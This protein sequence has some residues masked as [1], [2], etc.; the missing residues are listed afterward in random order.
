MAFNIGEYRAKY[1]AR[2][3]IEID[4]RKFTIR[5]LSPLDIWT[6][7]PKEAPPAFTR[8]ITIAGTVDPPL[9][10]AATDGRMGIDELEWRHV[11]ALMT[12]IV[13]FS[14]MGKT[15]FLSPGATP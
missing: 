1:P 11:S 10:E 4:G 5:R 2:K 14:G 9:S 7:T 15:D 13:E 8:R 6:E 3:E 12:A